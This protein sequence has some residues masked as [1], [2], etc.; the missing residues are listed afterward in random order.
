LDNSGGFWAALYLFPCSV[1]PQL[2]PLLH[3]LPLALRLFAAPN[4][5]SCH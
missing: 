2:Q 5:S 1:S 3:L 4:N